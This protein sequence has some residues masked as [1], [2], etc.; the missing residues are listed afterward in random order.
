MEREL[1]PRLYQ[2]VMDVRMSRYRL[3]RICRC[4]LSS[5]HIVLLAFFW[6]APA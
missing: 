5:A 6:A 4:A 2:L 3:N 1:W